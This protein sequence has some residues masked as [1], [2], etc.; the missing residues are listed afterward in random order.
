MDQTEMHKLAA[1]FARIAKLDHAMTYLGWD[2][3]VM[4]PPAGSTGRSEAIAELASLRHEALVAPEVGDWLAQAEAS[5]IT[6]E[7]RARLRE[8]QREHREATALPA[9]LVR[10]RITVG[11]AC[12]QGW[13]QQRPDNDW[14]GFLENFKPVVTIAREVAD[15][16]RAAEPDVYA[17]RYDALMAQHCNGDKPETV[18]AVFAELSE[19]LPQLLARVMAHQQAHPVPTIAGPFAREQQIDL[20]RRLAIQLGFDFESGRLDTSLHPFSTGSRGDLRITTRYVDED[21]FDALQATAHEIG[22]ASYEGGLPELWANEPVGASRSMSVHE[23]QSLFF[24]KHLFLSRAFQTG[25]ASAIHESLPQLKSHSGEQFWRSQL[26]VGPSHI[27]VEADEVTYPLH[28]LLRFEIERDLMNGA[29]EASD[30]PEAWAAS[31]QRLLGIDTRGDFT[32]GCL[33]DIHWTDGAFGYFPSYTLGAVNAAQLAATIDKDLPNWRH[34]LEQGSAD[35][36]LQLR[37]WLGKHIWSRASTVDADT[38]I[39]EAT[40]ASADPAHLLAHLERRYIDE[41]V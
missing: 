1:R 33:Q 22:H 14:T 34:D 7:D 12:E 27:R 30:V 10:A 26:G 41:A 32:N 29:I 9:D 37:G 2:Q 5:V 35:V 23:S 11:S 38:L 15:A 3:M 8:M 20:G 39:R 13:R 40:G 31:M 24:E 4:M 25:F 16:Y 36:I 6:A 19:R 21:L 28:V 17:T 18:N